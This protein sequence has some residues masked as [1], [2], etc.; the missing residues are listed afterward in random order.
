MDEFDNDKDTEVSFDWVEPEF[1]DPPADDP[2]RLKV[3]GMVAGGIR[4]EVMCRTILDPLMGKP[5]ELERFKRVFSNELSGGAELANAKA[6][7]E[8]FMMTQSAT[9]DDGIKL[10]AVVTF[11][12]RLDKKRMGKTTTTNVNYEVDVRIRNESIQRLIGM[13]KL[14]DDLGSAKR[15]LVRATPPKLVEAQRVYP[16]R[17][18]EVPGG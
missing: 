5:M 9:P 14:L 15:E 13:E 4:P 8:F 6:Y 1:G 18:E 12:E 7:A 17:T 16:E 3:L 11:L 10:K 2:V